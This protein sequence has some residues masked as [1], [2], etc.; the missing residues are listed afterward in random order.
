[1]RS[2][3]HALASVPSAYRVG[4]ALLLAAAADI[5][6]DPVHTH[7]PLCPFKAITGW[8]C[9]LCGGLRAVYEVAHLRIGTA[10]RDNVLVVAALPVIVTLWLAWVRRGAALRG[11]RWVWPAL[12]LLGV[13]FTVVRNLLPLGVLRP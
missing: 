8:Q 9:P 13:L 5:A 7:V 4:A 3:R 12:V 2:R 10:L 1:V 11:P 6:L